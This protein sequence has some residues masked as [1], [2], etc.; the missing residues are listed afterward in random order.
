MSSSGEEEVSASV[1]P[2]T[3]GDVLAEG[4]DAQVVQRCIDAPRGCNT[5]FGDSND[6]RTCAEQFH[7]I[8]YALT[9]MSRDQ[10]LPA[11]QLAT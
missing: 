11:S 3:L 7:Q 4:L 8:L 5:V 2:R 9:A 10:V 6:M 1:S